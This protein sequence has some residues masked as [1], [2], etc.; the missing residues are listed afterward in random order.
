V[1]DDEDL[2]RGLAEAVLRRGGYDVLQACD[3]D[4]ALDIFRTRSREID[5]VLLDYAMPRM[6]GLQVMRELQ[7]IDPGVC[8]VFSS[9]FTRDSDTDQLLATGAR[10]FLPKPYRPDDLLELVRRALRESREPPPGT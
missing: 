7:R 2:V 9:G 8:V 5:L 4:E 1:V 6:T 10:A 3:G